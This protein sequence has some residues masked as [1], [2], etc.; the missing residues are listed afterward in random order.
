MTNERWSTACHEAGHAVAGLALGGQC[1]GLLLHLDGGSAFVVGLY[2]DR[3][4]YMIAA[5]KEAERLANEFDAP[6]CEPIPLDEVASNP[7][8]EGDRTFAQWTTVANVPGVNNGSV[9]DDRSLALWAI[10]GRE[11]EPDTWTRRL[12]IARHVADEIVEQNATAIVRIASAL[13][14]KGALTAPEIR[15]LYE[16]PNAS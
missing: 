13:F 2:Q 1:N 10:G 6:T 16:E 11:S 9:S 12:A 4:A 14:Q 8:T 5:G 7:P 15:S 3:E